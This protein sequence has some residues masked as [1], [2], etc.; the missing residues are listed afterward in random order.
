MKVVAQQLQNLRP[1][2]DTSVSFIHNPERKKEKGVEEGH[3]TQGERKYAVK[4]I[5]LSI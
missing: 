4:N 5:T 2:P 1:Y 3:F